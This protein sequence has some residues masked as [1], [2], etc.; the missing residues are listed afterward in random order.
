MA[1]RELAL[2][3]AATRRTGRLSGRRSRSLRLRLTSADAA[4]SGHSSLIGG[5]TA[6]G[7][8]ETL[9]VW[10]AASALVRTRA[11]TNIETDR[12]NWGRSLP[13][14]TLS[15]LHKYGIVSYERNDASS[16]KQVKRR[17]IGKPPLHGPR[18]WFLS[19]PWACSWSADYG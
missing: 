19:P 4:K 9:P 14:K 13:F 5:T 6:R 15:L 18:F 11:R 2:P 17:W 3:S 1:A 8:K 10:A 16:I 12:K 7:P